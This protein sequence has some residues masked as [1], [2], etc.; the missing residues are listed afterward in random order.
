MGDI[1]KHFSRYEF[2]CNCG[3]KSDTVDVELIMLC[4]TVREFVG[5][6][7]IPNSGHRCFKHNYDEGG[8]PDSQHV[9]GKAADLP[10]PNPSKVYKMLNEKFPNKYGFGL[11][12]TF[13]H[14]DCRSKLARW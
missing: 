1:S 3:C 2:E 7:I 10:V 11:Y 12:A 8:Q 6:S 13:I 9:L 14:V 4:E 5:V